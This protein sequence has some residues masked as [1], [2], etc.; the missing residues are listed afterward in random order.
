MRKTSKFSAVNL[1]SKV[2]PEQN[3]KVGQSQ[4]HKYQNKRYTEQ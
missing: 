3:T 4:V 1:K 2:K